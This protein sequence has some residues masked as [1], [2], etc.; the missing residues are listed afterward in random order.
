MILSVLIMLFVFPSIL[1]SQTRLGISSLTP[2]NFWGIT[3]SSNL[4]GD[5][6]IV[7][8]FNPGKSYSSYDNLPPESD[9]I[10]GTRTQSFSS[11]R[12]CYSLSPLIRVA[13]HLRL[14]SGL[15]VIRVKRY[16]I[17][18]ADYYGNLPS[19][20]VTIYRDSKRVR[21]REA[22]FTEFGTVVGAIVDVSRAFVQVGYE[23]TNGG[24]IIGFGLSVR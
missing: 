3:A 1:M 9:W 21:D 20:E 11:G 13:D 15:A 19:G 23:V 5:V 14:F 8:I 12:L 22:D 18:H 7:F 17:V 2:E 4:S 24:I 6:G 16:R 10:P